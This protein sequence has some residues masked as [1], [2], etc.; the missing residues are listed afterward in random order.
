MTGYHYTLV[1]HLDSILELGLLLH[2]L[3]DDDY[4][5]LST[6]FGA[7]FPTNG[8]HVFREKLSPEHAFLILAWLAL[9]RDNYDLCL[10]EVVYYGKDT[11][12]RLA[13]HDETVILRSTFSVFNSC[14]EIKLRFDLILEPVPPEN[15][16]L[17]KTWDL[18]DFAS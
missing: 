4:A 12:Q 5:R 18:C 6:P 15:I 11:Q 17:L 1:K 13:N 16:R 7:N 9:G 14:T 10:L 3:S 8:I 2:P